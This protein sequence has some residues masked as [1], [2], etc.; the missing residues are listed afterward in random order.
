MRKM[1]CFPT[2][3]CYMSQAWD[4]ETDLSPG[5]TWHDFSVS[6]LACQAGVFWGRSS[7]ELISL[8]VEVSY[9]LKK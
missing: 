3:T 6:K 5:Q 8:Q 9:M 4:K 7:T 2:C 1:L